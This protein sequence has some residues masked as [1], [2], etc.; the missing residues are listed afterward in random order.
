MLNV[1]Y[2]GKC[3]CGCNKSAHKY[4]RLFSGAYEIIECKECS[5]KQYNHFNNLE[6][7]E[8]YAARV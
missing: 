6:Y 3:R 5:C 7:L 2:K 4:Y 1:A 8:F